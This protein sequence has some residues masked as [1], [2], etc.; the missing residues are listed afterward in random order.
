MVSKYP[1]VKFEIFLCF[2]IASKA[3]IKTRRIWSFALSRLAESDT[4]HPCKIA[5]AESCPVFKSLACPGN[6]GSPSKIKNPHSFRSNGFYLL[7]YPA[8]AGRFIL[9]SSKS[10]IMNNFSS[11]STFEMRVKEFL[12]LIIDKPP[13]SGSFVGACQCTEVSCCFDNCLKLSL[14]RY[15]KFPPA[16]MAFHQF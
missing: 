15:V 16:D 13:K 10:G 11:N 3:R 12:I 8:L 14:L 2:L 4:C 6:C 7:S 1:I 5:F 9:S